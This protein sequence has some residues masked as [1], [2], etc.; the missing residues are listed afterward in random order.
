MNEEVLRYCYFPYIKKI[1]SFI[2]CVQELIPDFNYGLYTQD[3]SLKDRT[4][5]ARSHLAL[6]LKQAGCLISPFS[7]DDEWDVYL[8]PQEQQV[9]DKLPTDSIQKAQSQ[10]D[11]MLWH[12]QRVVVTPNDLL[13]TLREREIRFSIRV[14]YV[15]GAFLFEERELLFELFPNLEKVVLFEPVPEVYQQLLIIT[16]NDPR[17]VV[18]PYAIGDTDERRDFYITNNYQSSSILPLGKLGNV[19]TS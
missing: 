8:A 4:F 9:L 10:E 14:L 13:L 11:L 16:K 19:P 3:M 2:P 12:P 1:L 15:V 6:K 5:F 18:F 17:I 7:I